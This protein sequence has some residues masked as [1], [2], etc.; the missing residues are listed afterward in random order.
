MAGKKGRFTHNQGRIDPYKNFNFRL[1]ITTVVAAIA[2][3]GLVKKLLLGA[4]ASKRKSKD[5]LTPTPVEEP[6]R[7]INSVGTSTARG[8]RSRSKA[9]RGGNS[10]SSRGRKGASTRRTGKPKSR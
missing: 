1:V 8:S 2:G 3:L 5:Y 7:P 10:S 6:P 9:G 4:P